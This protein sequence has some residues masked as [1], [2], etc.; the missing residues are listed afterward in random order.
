MRV[1]LWIIFQEGLEHIR[2]QNLGHIILLVF[3]PLDALERCHCIETSTSVADGLFCASQLKDSDPRFETGSGY[4]SN[5][6]QIVITNLHK[7]VHLYHLKQ[8]IWAAPA[9]LGV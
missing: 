7:Y 5:Y 3:K 2:E 8:R 6:T 1:E 9:A 4:S